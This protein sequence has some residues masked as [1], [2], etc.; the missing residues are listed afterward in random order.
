MALNPIRES[1]VKNRTM[2][3]RH[4]AMTVFTLSLPVIY[5]LA[6]FAGNFSYSKSAVVALMA[7]IVLA[8]AAYAQA[9]I[10]IK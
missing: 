6:V 5:A 2:T 8:L 3:A 1:L 9:K 10:F 4:S 7:A